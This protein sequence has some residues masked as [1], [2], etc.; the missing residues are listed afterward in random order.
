MASFVAYLAHNLVNYDVVA[1]GYTMYLFVGLAQASWLI[2]ERKKTETESAPEPEFLPKD[3]KPR[4]KKKRSKKRKRTTGKPKDKPSLSPASGPMFGALVVVAGASVFLPVIWALGAGRGRI[5]WLLV[6]PAMP[7]G[8]ILMRATL[9]PRDLWKKLGIEDPLEPNRALSLGLAYGLLWLFVA[10]PF[11]AADFLYKPL[12]K[13]VA[14]IVVAAVLDGPFILMAVSDGRIFARS[15]EGKVGSWKYVGLAAVGAAAMAATAVYCAKHIQADWGIYR[16]KGYAKSVDRQ[17]RPQMDR[18]KRAIRAL[19]QRAAQLRN[20]GR[21]VP[22]R[23]SVQ[24]S[25]FQEQRIK[26]VEKIE[27][28]LETVVHNG[29]MATR[30]FR[31]MGFFHHQY[32]KSLQPFLREAGTIPVQRARKLMDEAVRHAQ[33]AVKN[34]TNPESAYSHLAVIH[35]W[36]MRNCNALPRGGQ[37]EKCEKR[38]FELSKA[39]LEK[40]ISH[41]RYYYDTHRM[42]AFLLLREKK[43]DEAIREIRFAKKIIRNHLRAFGNVA[44]VDSMI[45]RTLLRKGIQLAKQGKWTEAMDVYRGA[46]N[47]YGEPM[48]EAHHL[49]GNALM[50][51]KRVGEAEQELE[52]ALSQK[53]RFFAAM[54]DLARL[55]LLQQ[56]LSRAHAL[57]QK[58]LSPRVRIPEALLVRA[59]AYEMERRVNEAL[60][61]YRRY[62]KL[63]PRTPQAKRVRQ[64]IA[65]LESNR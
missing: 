16:A 17:I 9:A 38:R 26:L 1:T 40:S 23:L 15:T 4:D 46:I 7:L 47:R 42:K 20:A 5:L 28:R 55:R 31:F 65:E 58:L 41:D 13:D 48:P 35:Y 21:T 59:W 34:N 37:R 11:V 39:A 2:A 61:D 25:R 51:L 52:L 50:R 22:V 14:L 32:S 44:K 49:M 6:T 33:M 18:V 12:H 19:N 36:S 8:A 30:H 60:S 62:L 27:K 53:K 63:R 24:L 56:D 57:L 43:I 54:L 3:T 64:K 10:V 29:R 45:K